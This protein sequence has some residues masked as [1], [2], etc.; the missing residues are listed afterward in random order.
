MM[1]P[2]PQFQI[3]DF[4]NDRTSG[5][6]KPEYAYEHID[7]QFASGHPALKRPYVRR[8]LI[9]DQPTSSLAGA[10]P[11][12]RARLAQAGEPRLQ[13]VREGSYKQHFSNWAYNPHRVISLLKRRGCTGGPKPPSAGNNDIF[14]YPGVG[15]LSSASS[16]PPGTSSG[17]WRSR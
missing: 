15:R 7:I 14:S 6:A 5:P 10:V 11:K 3:A 2:Q 8:A 17:R 9:T 16:R 1:E 13:D 4:L 12:A